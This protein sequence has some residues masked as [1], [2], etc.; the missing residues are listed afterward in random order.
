MRTPAFCL[1]CGRD[2]NTGHGDTA[3]VPAVPIIGP[4]CTDTV[5]AARLRSTVETILATYGRDAR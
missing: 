3:C 1:F 2:Y 5:E 4:C